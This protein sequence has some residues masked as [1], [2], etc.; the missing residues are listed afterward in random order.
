MPTREESEIAWVQNC[1]ASGWWQS[2]C[3]TGDEEGHHS[4][5]GGEVAALG[6]KDHDEKRRCEL[7]ASGKP[8]PTP[9]KVRRGKKSRATNAMS[10]TLI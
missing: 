2:R 1:P 6:E 3:P 4:D 10:T 5:G 8:P 7:H 9:P